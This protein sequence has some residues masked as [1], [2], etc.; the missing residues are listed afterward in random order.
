MQLGWTEGEFPETQERRWKDVGSR[1]PGEGE[2]LR[3]EGVSACEDTP[4]SRGPPGFRRRLCSE[5]A[6]AEEQVR[7][8]TRLFKSGVKVPLRI[9]FPA[10]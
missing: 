5:M 7:E 9:A 2:D 6:E 3:E 4:C 8:G 1:S 10:G